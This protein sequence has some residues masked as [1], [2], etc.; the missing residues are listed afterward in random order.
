MAGTDHPDDA[1][2]YRLIYR[3]RNRIPQEER[4]RELEELFGAAVADEQDTPDIPL[5]AHV[6]GIAAAAPRSAAT[7]DQ[8]RVLA[9]MRDAARGR[10]HA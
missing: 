8:E 2:V 5:I 6:E 9:V 10:L 3:S 4:R 1:V 7:A